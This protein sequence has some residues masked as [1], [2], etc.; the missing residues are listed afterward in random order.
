[1]PRST[2][3]AQSVRMKPKPTAPPDPSP[4]C[5]P[6]R[7]RRR[8]AEEDEPAAKALDGE[9]D[10]AIAGLPVWD[11]DADCVSAVPRQPASAQPTFTPV[12]KYHRAGEHE[13]CGVGTRA[14]SSDPD[15]DR[16]GRAV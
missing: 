8:C 9:V 7:S 3:P 1:M 13:G 14:C 6:A 2:S 10:L 4:T 11:R 15:G 16:R 5:G 12:P